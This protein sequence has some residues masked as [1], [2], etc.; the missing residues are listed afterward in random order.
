M[1]TRE[2]VILILML[3]TIA[4]GSYIYFFTSPSETDVISPEKEAETL[5]KFMADLA[6]TLKESKLSE[7]DTY[8]L[9][10]AETGWPKDPLLQPGLIVKSEV[11]VEKKDEVFDEKINFTYS[12]YLD[13]GNRRLAIIDGMEYEAGEALEDGK[14]YI[15]EISPVQ[16]VIGATKGNREIIFHL[17][18]AD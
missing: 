4:G 1:T 17:E 7:N 5:N 9:S 3:L 18:E 8:L 14:Y 15:K 16:V 11:T 2:R 6:R 13:V 10:R 12:G